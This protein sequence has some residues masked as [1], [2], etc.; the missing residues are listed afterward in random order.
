MSTIDQRY[1]LRC[2]LLIYDIISSHIIQSSR[3]NKQ[4]WNKMDKPMMMDFSD[5]NDVMFS[6]IV[7]NNKF[8]EKLSNI[9]QMHANSR[10]KRDADYISTK[11]TFS[12]LNEKIVK[13]CVLIQ[14]QINEKNGH[15]KQ[16]DS[17]NSN[18]TEIKKKPPTTSSNEGFSKTEIPE[19][20]SLSRTQENYLRKV[21]SSAEN[22]LNVPRQQ[23]KNSMIDKDDLIHLRNSSNLVVK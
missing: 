15:K 16:N 4:N 8:F 18:N 9:S 23:R 11:S 14:L 10:I 19:N 20:W 3:Q 13:D 17:N 6:F 2:Q 22:L 21:D 5:K 7:N 1:Q 12:N